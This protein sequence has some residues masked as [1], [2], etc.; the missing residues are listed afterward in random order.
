MTAAYPPLVAPWDG[1]PAYIV[2]E[3]R[4]YLAMKLSDPGVATLERLVGSAMDSARVY[5][6]WASIPDTDQSWVPDPVRDS[7]IGLLA[8]LYRRKELSFNVLGTVDPDGIGFRVAADWLA[9]NCPNLHQYK[10]GWGLA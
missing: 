9:S 8:E 1:D 5:L 4:K 3:A 6:G 7:C 10:I 2:D